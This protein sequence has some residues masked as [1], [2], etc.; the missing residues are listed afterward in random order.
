MEESRKIK[1]KKIRT[2]G[3]Y[4]NMIKLTNFLM[5]RRKIFISLIGGNGILIRNNYFSMKRLARENSKLTSH[6]KIYN[7]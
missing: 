7:K 4:V 5:E 2:K 6:V 3:D 1:E